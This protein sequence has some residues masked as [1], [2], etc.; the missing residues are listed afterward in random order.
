M[1][2]AGDYLPPSCLH[3]NWLMHLRP[4]C[5]AQAKVKLGGDGSNRT[6]RAARIS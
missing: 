3:A 6:N 5:K 4:C 1:E 2:R